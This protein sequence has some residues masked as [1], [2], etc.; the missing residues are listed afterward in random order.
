MSDANEPT[1]PSTVA[2][3]SALGLTVDIMRSLVRA[4]LGSPLATRR[5]RGRTT[6]MRSSSTRTMASLEVPDFDEENYENYVHQLDEFTPAESPLGRT[7]ILATSGLAP[8]V[9]PTVPECP[10][11]DELKSVT[12]ARENSQDSTERA[13]GGVFVRWAEEAPKGMTCTRSW[14]MCACGAELIHGCS[15]GKL[16]RRASRDPSRPGLG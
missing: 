10:A 12:P 5:T 9:A 11:P 2:S 14:S 6:R 15:L 3:S 8:G 16:I 13:L 4:R 1:E 7:G